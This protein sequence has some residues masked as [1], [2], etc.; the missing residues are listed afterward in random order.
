LG[1]TAPDIFFPVKENNDENLNLNSYE[2]DKCHWLEPVFNFSFS[3]AMP[4]RPTKPES[5]NSR[6]KTKKIKIKRA[7]TRKQKRPPPTLPW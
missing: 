6:Q 7:K 4:A 5:R 2:K 3:S 1:L